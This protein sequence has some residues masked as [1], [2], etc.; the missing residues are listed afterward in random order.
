M[1]TSS[2]ISAVDIAL[3]DLAAKRAGQPLWRHLGGFDPAVPC[4]AGGIDLQFPLQQLLEQAEEFVVGKP[5]I[6]EVGSGGATGLG[7]QAV[8][9][10]GFDTLLEL[11]RL[12][13]LCPAGLPVPCE[14]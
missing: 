4:Y 9:E 7:I 11:L 14:E 1:P 8:F 13:S 2:A 10:Q 5:R 6:G 12:P 3:W